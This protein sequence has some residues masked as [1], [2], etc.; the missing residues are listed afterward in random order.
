LA[1]FIKPTSQLF[2]DSNHTIPQK[3]TSKKPN[4]RLNLG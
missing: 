3:I 1:M 4:S 2:F